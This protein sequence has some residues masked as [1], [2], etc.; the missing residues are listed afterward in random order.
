M[1]AFIGQGVD[2]YDCTN[3]LWC[4]MRFMLSTNMK[5]TPRKTN[6][7]PVQEHMIMMK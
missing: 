4:C 5:G 7:V 1:N 3:A 6:H 2:T